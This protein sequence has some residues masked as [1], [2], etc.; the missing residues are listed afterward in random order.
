[1]RNRQKKGSLIMNIIEFM[2]NLDA[3]ILC[4]IIAL[5][6]SIIGTILGAFLTF[7]FNILN[8]IIKR[9][10]DHIVHIRDVK[11]NIYQKCCELLDKV[12][13]LDKNNV[14]NNTEY[15]ERM[16]DNFI[17][18]SVQMKLFAPRHIFENFVELVKE[19]SDNKDIS[20]EKE[21]DFINIL[22]K[23][24]KIEE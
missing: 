17:S 11:E 22:R 13:L 14:I 21:K 1:M 4:A 10:R 12:T 24:L 9:N 5:I 15:Y 18:I 20:N 16:V 8:E 19:F 3:K 23:D 2:K 6:S 7:I